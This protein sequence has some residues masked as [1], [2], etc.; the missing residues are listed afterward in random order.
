MKEN[1]SFGI[2]DLGARGSQWVGTILD[3]GDDITIA[4]V[5]DVYQHR[6]DDAIKL[7][8]EKTGKRPTGT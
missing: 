3:M 7:V 6:I 5:C 2:I 4:W 8:K 1:V